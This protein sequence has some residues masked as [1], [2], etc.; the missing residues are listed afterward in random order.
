MSNLK[1]VVFEGYGM[2]MLVVY[3][4]L[5]ILLLMFNAGAHRK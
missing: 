5:V 3:T 1:K 2:R 4:V